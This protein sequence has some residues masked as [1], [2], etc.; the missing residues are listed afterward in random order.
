MKNDTEF[1]FY[2][3]IAGKHVKYGV[4][5]PDAPKP[6]PSSL[7]KAGSADQ[8]GDDDDDARST[9]TRKHIAFEDG[10]LS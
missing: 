5:D 9:T 6:P 2:M 1:C 10:E 7:R 8:S 3:I 4:P